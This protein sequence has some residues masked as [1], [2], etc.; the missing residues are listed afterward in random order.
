MFILFF[1][2]SI[3]LTHHFIFLIFEALYIFWCPYFRFKLIRLFRTKDVFHRVN[4]FIL[5]KKSVSLL[6]HHESS[7]SMLPGI[8]LFSRLF[9]NL[10]YLTG[11]SR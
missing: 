2:V 7:A 1:A 3:S 6:L 4:S 10:R 11:G 8:L 9:V 5:R